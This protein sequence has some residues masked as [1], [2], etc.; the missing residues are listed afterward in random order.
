MAI[1]FDTLID[2]YPD[3]A[4]W[5]R[6]ESA[7]IPSI[8]PLDPREFMRDT[9]RTLMQ[10]PGTMLAHWNQQLR[11]FTKQSGHPDRDWRDIEAAFLEQN[12]L[13]TGVCSRILEIALSSYPQM[14]CVTVLCQLTER[15]HR[16]D[17][18]F[19]TAWAALNANR[20]DLCIAT[21]DRIENTTAQVLTIQGQAWL[22]SGRPAESLHCFDAAVRLESDEVL[23]WF[24]KA[25]ACHVME[26]WQDCWGSLMACHQLVPDSDEIAT[27]CA[28]C[29]LTAVPVRPDWTNRAW[30]LLL[31]FLPG[32]PVKN[33]VW[34]TLADLALQAEIPER[35]MLL[36]N[37]PVADLCVAEPEFTPFVIRAQEKMAE[38]KDA[39]KEASLQM[40][41]LQSAR[42]DQ[43]KAED[44]ATGPKAS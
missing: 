16:D 12:T 24:Q 2:D 19:L 9:C 37:H 14:D 15:L 1:P 11:T 18:H 32:S 10:P 44:A 25:K 27:F 6:R 22:E 29:A 31:P 41:L 3:L 40:G 13:L 21:C 4:M 30:D 38:K 23:A 33:A 8:D 34:F 39:W 36:L 20:Y 28:L 42:G 43:P 35:L 5:Y 17:F 7:A 26:R